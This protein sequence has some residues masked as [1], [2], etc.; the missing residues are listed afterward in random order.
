ME[1]KETEI[2]AIKTGLVNVKNKIN[3][4][5]ANISSRLWQISLYKSPIGKLTVNYSVTHSDNL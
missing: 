5:G 2:E 1:R 4:M 3:E